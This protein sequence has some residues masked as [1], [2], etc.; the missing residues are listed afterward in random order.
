MPQL[1]AL[2]SSLCSRGHGCP[3]VTPLCAPTATPAGKAPVPRVCYILFPWLQNTQPCILSTSPRSCQA[4]LRFGAGVLV[5]LPCP[6]GS[7]AMFLTLGLALGLD[8]VIPQKVSFPEPLSKQPPGDHPTI[9]YTCRDIS[10][11]RG[12]RDGTVCAA[13]LG[14]S[15]RS[16]SCCPATRR[17]L[18]S[19][20]YLLSA[21][22]VL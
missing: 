6:W 3:G 18:R 20:S 15:L 21:G 1:P 11:P 8:A 12:E 22:L 17:R 14:L 16:S 9:L 2:A 19:F 7:A 10:D 13:Q 4:A 5:H